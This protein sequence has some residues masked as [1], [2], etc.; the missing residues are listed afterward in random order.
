MYL[1]IAIATLVENQRGWSVNPE[2]ARQ[3]QGGRRVGERGGRGAG[4]PAIG[5]G[6]GDNNFVGAIAIAP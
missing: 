1:L 5:R 2:R 3:V 6:A 4:E